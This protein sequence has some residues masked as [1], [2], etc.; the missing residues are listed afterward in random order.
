MIDHIDLDTCPVS[1]LVTANPFAGCDTTPMDAKFRLD[2]L[3]RRTFLKLGALACSQGVAGRLWGAEPERF[4]L[5]YAVGSSMYGNLPLVTVVGEVRKTGT[6]YIDLWPRKWG[7]QRE[8][9]EAMGHD[10]FGELLQQNGVKVGLTTRFDLG[11]FKLQDEMR[12]LRRFGGSAVVVGYPTGPHG[13]KGPALREAIRSLVEQMKPHLAAAEEAGVTI[14]FENH[15]DSTIESPDAIRWLCEFSKG[16][17]LGIALSPYHLDQDPAMLAGLIR[18]M[19]PQLTLFYGWQYGMGCMK[20]MPPAEETMQLPGKGKLD[21][22][23]LLQALKDTRFRGWTEIFMHHTPRG[24]PIYPTA[25]PITEDIISAQ[26]Y[27]A[28]RMAKLT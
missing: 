20:P 27:L 23:P 4:D 10:K 7:G 25:A 17:P 1:F 5:R 18:D 16:M 12:F 15:G 28:E 26:R 22:Q 9:V 8:E 3:D 11:P 19:G 2:R 6:D 13:L 24:V 14:A 21:F